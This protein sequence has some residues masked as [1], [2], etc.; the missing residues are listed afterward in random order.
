MSDD[1]DNKEM[2]VDE[3]RDRLLKGERLSYGRSY[4]CDMNCVH[5]LLFKNWIHDP[6]SFPHSKHT[7][8]E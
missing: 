8:V 4:T 3:I 1:G 5:N 6:G 2:E 7:K